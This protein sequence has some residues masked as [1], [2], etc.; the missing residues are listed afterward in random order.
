MKYIISLLACI[1]A[2]YGGSIV[3]GTH[4]QTYTIGI[5]VYLLSLV[6]FNLGISSDDDAYM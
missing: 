3:G 5:I 2:A 6:I 1:A 4:I